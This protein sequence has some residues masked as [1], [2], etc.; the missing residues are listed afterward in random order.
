MAWSA[1]KQVHERLVHFD[2]RRTSVYVNHYYIYLIDPE[3]GPAFIKIC[4]YAPYAVKVCLNGHVRHEALL[5]PSGDERAPPLGCRSS[6]AKLRAVR[7]RKRGSSP[8][9]D[10]TTGSARRSRLG[11]RGGK[12]YARNQRPSPSS[13]RRQ[14]RTWRIWVGQQ[15]VST[16]WTT[17]SPGCVPRSGGHGEKPAAYPWQGCRGTVGHRTHQSDHSE[18]GNHPGASPPHTRPGWVEGKARCRRIAPGWDGV[19]VVV[20]GRETRLHGEGGQQCSQSRNGRSGGR[21]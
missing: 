10:E 17:P 19:L 9:N 18:R 15:C 7:S 14:P 20:R 3:W 6:L 16:R 4:G 5:I 13:E 8:H 11:K 12:L 2:F 21:W 1:T